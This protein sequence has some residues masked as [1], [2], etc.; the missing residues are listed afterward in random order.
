VIKTPAYRIPEIICFRCPLY[1]IEKQCKKAQTRASVIKTHGVC[2]KIEYTVHQESKLFEA[3]QKRIKRISQE[4]KAK[5][6]AMGA[7]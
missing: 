2:R 1:D 7:Y 3:A 5:R 4:M 6:K